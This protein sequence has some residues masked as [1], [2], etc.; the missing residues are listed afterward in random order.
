MFRAF[1]DFSRQRL[2]VKED[3]KLAFSMAA[4]LVFSWSLRGF[5]FNVPA[6]LLSY[7]VWDILAIA[8][9]MLSF[10]LLETL[11]VTGGMVLLAAL[12][13]QKILK[14]GF[15]YKAAWFFLAFG[16]VSVH[17]QY[18]MSNQ[19][20]TAFLLRELFAGLALWLLPALLTQFI[21]AVRR[22]VLDLLDRLTIFSYLYVPLGMISLIV[23]VLR[24]MW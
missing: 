24:L 19:P 17:I 21:G 8:A 4:L 13:P 16:L 3:V 10:A 14:E 9:Y 7:T 1:L 2:P 23:V 20:K 6:Y 11:L 5:F 22:V 18:T 12:L 15:S